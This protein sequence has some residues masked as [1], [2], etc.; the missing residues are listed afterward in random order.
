M[1]L[2]CSF[3]LDPSAD[4]LRRLE[5]GTE[6]GALWHGSG[7]CLLRHLDAVQVTLRLWSLTIKAEFQNRAYCSNSQLRIPLPEV[8]ESGS[9]GSCLVWDGDSV[10]LG[11]GV[12]FKEQLLYAVFFLQIRHR[13]FLLIRVVQVLSEH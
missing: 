13:E 10:C 4:A 12:V 2:R 6:R 3:V 11:N 1:Q 7:V 5:N 8:V 9:A